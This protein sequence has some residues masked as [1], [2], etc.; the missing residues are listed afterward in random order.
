MYDGMF[1]ISGY[2]MKIFE[3]QVCDYRHFSYGLLMALEFLG[4]ASS[5]PNDT[6]AFSVG[7][8]GSVVPVN[9]SSTS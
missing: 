6:S 3:Q 2:K 9:H 1:A 7:R 4:I 8:M 5:N